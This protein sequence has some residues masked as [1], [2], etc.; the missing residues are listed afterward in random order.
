MNF[1]NSVA[2]GVLNVVEDADRPGIIVFVEVQVVVMF[3]L[4]SAMKTLVH[5]RCRCMEAR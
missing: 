1:G 2:H 5:V 4:L 3:C